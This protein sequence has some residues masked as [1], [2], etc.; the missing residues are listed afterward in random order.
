MTLREARV[1]FSR[2]IAEHVLWLFEQGYEVAFDE[3]TER[4]TAKDPTSDHMKN[5][6]HHLGL[7]AD[8]NLYLDGSYLGAT[9]DHAASGAKWK[10]RHPL[11]RWGGDFPADGNHYSI[12]YGGRA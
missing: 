11:C 6:A 9:S 1:L 3:V 7:A 4:L 8:L 10:S 2:L 5:S 12:T